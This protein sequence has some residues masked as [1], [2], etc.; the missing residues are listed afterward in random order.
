MS[1]GALCG[2]E[3]LLMDLE[4]TREFT[5]NGLEHPKERF[6]HGVIAAH[7]GSRSK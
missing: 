4:A 2:E 6:R 3:V 1:L 5:K 7:G